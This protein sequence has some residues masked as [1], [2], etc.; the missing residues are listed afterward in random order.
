M[1]EVSRRLKL[2]EE[3]LA[4]KDEEIQELKREVNQ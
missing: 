3:T 1:L 2:L 4:Y